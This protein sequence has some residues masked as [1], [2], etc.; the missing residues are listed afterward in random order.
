MSTSDLRIKVPSRKAP[1]VFSQECERTNPDALRRKLRQELLSG[2]GCDINRKL[3]QLV[4]TSG[5]RSSFAT[6]VCSCAIL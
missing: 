6:K 3:L 4:K 5:S 1:M 2:F